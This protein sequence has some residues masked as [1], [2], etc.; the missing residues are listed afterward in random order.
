MQR[1]LSLFAA[2]VALALAAAPQS[3]ADPFQY[4][5]NWTASPVSISAG[6]G[7]VSF[8]PNDGGTTTNETDTVATNI[9]VFSAAVSGN[10]D[11]ISTPVA[12]SNYMLAVTISD[13]IVGDATGTISFTGLLQG[14]L[15][16]DSSNLSNAITGVTDENGAHP[17]QTLGVTTVGGQRFDVSYDGF[18]APGP[19]AQHNQGAI[20][21]YIGFEAEI[22]FEEHAAAAPSAPEP[23]SMVL[24]CLGLSFLG[25][26][27]YRVRGR[28]AAVQNAA[29]RLF[30][31]Q[32]LGIA[33]QAMFRP[34]AIHLPQHFLDHIHVN[35]HIAIFHPKSP[36]VDR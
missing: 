21:F 30:L 36:D 15:T 13:G 27:V 20:S 23:S 11:V 28:K 10:P 5:Y 3:Q 33:G 14:R 31:S 6:T 9:S 17:G 26:A 35:A 8:T 1:S 16:H 29:S 19:E 12:G 4:S 25:G 2:T 22:A 32:S 18:A 34:D 24:G 7:V